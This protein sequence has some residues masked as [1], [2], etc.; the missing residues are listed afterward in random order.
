VNDDKHRG[1]VAMFD[2]DRGFGFVTPDDARGGDVF[3]H[4]SQLLSPDVRTGDRVKFVI[5]PDEKR[6]GRFRAGGV[7]RV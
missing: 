2:P 6:S 1:V 7:E 4:H 3:F 5:Q